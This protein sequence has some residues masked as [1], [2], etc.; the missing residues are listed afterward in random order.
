MFFFLTFSTVRGFKH[1]LGVLE[2]IPHGKG[3][4]CCNSDQRVRENQKNALLTEDSFQDVKSDKVGA[5]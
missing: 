4:N 2:H 1:L 3:G 5:K